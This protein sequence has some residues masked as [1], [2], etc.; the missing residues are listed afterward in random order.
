MI[1]SSG[2][3]LIQKHSFECAN[4]SKIFR[5]NLKRGLTNPIPFAIIGLSDRE[6]EENNMKVEKKKL[7]KIERFEELKDG[8]PFYYGGELF[9]KLN[10]DYGDLMY[11]DERV[12]AVS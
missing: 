5:K 6:R 4:S 10:S 9:L 7:P 11:D 3:I 2:L 12:T 8:E 1:D